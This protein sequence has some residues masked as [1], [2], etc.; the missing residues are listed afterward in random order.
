MRA[1]HADAQ[2]VFERIGRA[3]GY[4]TRRTWNTDLP[5]DGVWL[6]RDTASFGVTLPIA[7]LEVV[8][9]E[10]P[11]SIK[12][13]ID[14]L[15]EVSPAVGVLVIHEVEIRRGLIRGGVAPTAADRAVAMQVARAVDRVKRHQQRI[16]VWSYAQL[17]RRYELVT[18]DM[19]PVLLKRISSTKERRKSH[20]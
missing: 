5:T 2:Y 12:G 1:G 16:V 13:S 20:A 18:G 14:T 3:G 17:R 19:S 8:V 11:K 4:V 7:A 6:L 10:G 15:A 9:S